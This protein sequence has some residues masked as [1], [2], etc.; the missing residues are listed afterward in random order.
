LLID[1]NAKR[2]LMKCLTLINA[3]KVSIRVPMHAVLDR[4]H[5]QDA[6][7][8]SDAINNEGHDGSHINLVRAENDISYSY[9][10]LGP[11]TL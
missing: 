9:K 5:R 7:A 4:T 3:G 2:R 6:D 8:D 10:W 1:N 11:N